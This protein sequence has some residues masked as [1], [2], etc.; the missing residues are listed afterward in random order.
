MS[1]INVLTAQVFNRI[2]AGEVVERPASIVKELVENSLDAG[3]SSI[4]IEVVDGGIKQIKVIDNG[5]G[6]VFEDLQKAFLPHAT[7]KIATVE[8]LEAIASLGFRGEALASIASVS[9]I[10]LTSKTA[11]SEVGGT[12]EIDG[13]KVTKHE[14]VASPNGTFITVNNLFYNTPARAKFL[15]KP[16]TEETKITNLVS[17]FILA[18]P[19]VSFTYIANG[20]EVY[21]ST[22]K[23]L[24]E[25][26]YTVYG[27]DTL[28]SLIPFE[29][30]VDDITISG[31]VGKPTYSKS[32]RT[33]QTLIINGRYVVNSTVSA[34]VYGAYS[35]YLMKGKFPFFIINLNMP[36]NSLDVNVH[37]NKLDVKFINSGRIYSLINNAV[38]NA[39]LSANNILRIE[40]TEEVKEQ[41]IPSAT[42]ESASG[43]S[44]KSDNKPHEVEIESTD[45]VQKQADLL[46]SF[47]SIKGSS[48]KT[49][50][51]ENTSVLTNSLHSSLNSIKEDYK[52]TVNET[53]IS[54]FESVM[55]G[56]DINYI[57]KVF[58]TFLLIEK[59][60][61]L[62][63]IDQH[64][65]HERL[66]YDKLTQQIN[67]KQI[68]SQMLLVPIIINT[69]HL[70]EE[71]MLEH[72]SDIQALG[73]EI[74]SFGSLSFKISSIP[75]VLM[76]LNVELFFNN[77]LKD[78]SVFNSLNSS[79]LINDKLKQIS[80]KSAVKG[81]DNLSSDEIKLLFEAM[82]KNNT[83]LLCPH[84]RPV[85]VEVTRKEIDKWFKRIV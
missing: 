12:L 71:F 42:Y 77:I 32:N 41:I 44:F 82:H 84:G 60:D 73:F 54:A 51:G 46:S 33:Y 7:S 63:L 14:E 58:N 81:G 59:Q 11:N 4:R 13:G 9:Q 85:I 21:R 64:A 35:N 38:V 18:N 27:K 48:N 43:A 8:D 76:G 55:D 30:K 68:E 66:K 74:E 56:S 40:N 65:A 29:E 26:V 79:D 75:A 17:R 5:S 2:A 49:A 1:K 36:H 45:L 70:E 67:N 47:E 34:S 69:N 57:G 23:N 53:Q 52:T 50:F 24:E 25:A 19:K 15:N 6:I 31:Y 61:S 16:K 37:P 10:E 62:Y 78:I 80:C 72:L 20:K 3:A 28:N 83:T 22:G 39:L